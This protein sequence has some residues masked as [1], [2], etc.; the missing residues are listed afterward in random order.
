M[1]T[2]IPIPFDQD[3]DCDERDS[4]V[5]TAVNKNGESRAEVSIQ[6]LFQG[7]P[8]GSEQTEV[9]AKVTDPVF[10][11]V[12][13]LRKEVAKWCSAQQQNRQIAAAAVKLNF[14]GVT[15]TDEKERISHAIKRI[16][17]SRHLQS[18]QLLKLFVSLDPN[19]KLAAEA[20]QQDFV[21]SN[22]SATSALNNAAIRRERGSGGGVAGAGVGGNGEMNL[23]PEQAE[24]MANMV[25]S[26][27]QI[28]DMMMNSDPTMREMMRTNPEFARQMRDPDTLRAIF[29]GQASREG[30]VM[31]DN[32]QRAALA[33]IQNHPEGNALIERALGREGI[34]TEN[35]ES[36]MFSVTNSVR[37]GGSLA[38]DE[39]ANNLNTNN[40]NNNNRP[41]LPT[42]TSTSSPQMT[43][44]FASLMGMQMPQI[45]M[46]NAASSNNNNP[47]AAMMSL[48]Q[49][50]MATRATQEAQQN[51]APRQSSSQTQQ[52]DK[53][54]EL[55]RSLTEEMG[56]DKEI[57]ELAANESRGDLEKALALLEEWQT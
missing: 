33:F 12:K 7:I 30:R 41:L 39:T 26:N 53:I 1:P 4:I 44:P 56:F 35:G 49:Q 14:I 3:I 31:Q 9:F 57:A 29:R 15:L 21:A 38:D 24:A 32:E 43:N 45:P 47:F 20:S 40:N 22:S 37:G 55:A 13:D 54:A 19:S 52:Q 23:S 34:L 42:T 18:P 6:L 16:L 11:L 17:K 46:N 50:L 48:Q 28:I 10:T 8:V 51:I 5:N 27:P 25:A 2:E 36:S